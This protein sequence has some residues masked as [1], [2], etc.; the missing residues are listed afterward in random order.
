MYQ[1]VKQFCKSNPAFSE[2]S[3]RYYIFNETTNGL[4][5]SGAIIRL[6]RKIL[7]NTCKFFA[8]IESENE[9]RA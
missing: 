1:S 4:A 2:S 9:K 3:V 6:G 8:W 5:E 7:I